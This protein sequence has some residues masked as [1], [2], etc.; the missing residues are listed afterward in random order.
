MV[1]VAGVLLSALLVLNPTASSGGP[2]VVQASGVDTCVVDDAVVSWGFK[3]S[4]RSYLSGAIALGKWEVSG[5]VSYETPLFGFSGGTGSIA[6][7]RHSGDIDFVGHMRFV[8][9]G[10]ILNTT[11][12]DPTLRFLGPREA[13][14]VFDVTG[15][16]MDFV[17]VETRDVDF[18]RLSWSRFDERVNSRTGV[19]E[20]TDARVTLTPAGSGA[21]GTYV[22]GAVF[23]PL[24]FSVSTTPGCLQGGVSWW[25]LPGGVVALA[26]IGSGVWFITRRGRK[27]PEPEHQ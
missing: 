6:P 2:G 23:D 20:V 24:S 10:G 7:N 22:A 3:E 15:D 17:F 5:D 11:L 16:T 1:S 12:S 18:V 21:F 27:S 13:A 9:H 14:L 25:W 8:G 26:V 4:F 19:L